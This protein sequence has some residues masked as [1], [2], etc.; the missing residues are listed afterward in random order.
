[1]YASIKRESRESSELKCWRV[2]RTSLGSHTNPTA[3]THTRTQRTNTQTVSELRVYWNVQENYEGTIGSSSNERT[4]PESDLG[5]QTFAVTLPWT[6]LVSYLGTV[7]R[8]SGAWSYLDCMFWVL[9]LGRRNRVR[10]CESG[11]SASGA[12]LFRMQRRSRLRWSRKAGR[13]IA[14]CYTLC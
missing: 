3:R 12:E 2:G 10:C 11:S 6:F 1:M 7:Q 8:S 9:F 13:C 4:D 14:L 5:P